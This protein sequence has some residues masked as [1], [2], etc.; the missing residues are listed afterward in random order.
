MAH[1]PS[2]HIPLALWQTVLA[3]LHRR[4]EEQHES[5]AFLLGRVEDQGREVERIVYYD[6]LDPGAY[7][8]GRCSDARRQLRQ[9]LGLVP[10][11][12]IVGGRRHPR[13][14]GR[15]LAEFCRPQQPDDCPTRTFGVDRAGIRAPT[16]PIENLGILRISGGTPLVALERKAHHPVSPY[17][18]VGDLNES[19]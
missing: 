13:S 14:S 2:L 3:E 1:N 19:S 9:A 18:Q 5:G 7:Q 12:Q 4:T 17:R 8:T 16:C 6:D 10:C 11:V 15:R